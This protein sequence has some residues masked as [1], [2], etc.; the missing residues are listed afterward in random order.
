MPDITF[1]EQAWDE[2]LA[3]QQD[4]AT[5]RRI[6][7]LLKEISRAPFEGAGKPE[8]L[9]HDRS[10]EWSSRINETERLIYTVRNGVTVV[11]QCKGH[12]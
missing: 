5:L 4:Q 7:A 9:R 11:L 12:Y 1:T 2:Y 8:P 10:G 3:W 6:S